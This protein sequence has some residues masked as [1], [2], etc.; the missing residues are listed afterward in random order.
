MNKSDGRKKNGRHMSLCACSTTNAL[1]CYLS[2]LDCY[3]RSSSVQA[4]A[5]S[6][7][8]HRNKQHQQSFFFFFIAALFTQR[9]ISS[10]TS[11]LSADIYIIALEKLCFYCT[12]TKIKSAQMDKSKKMHLSPTKT[13]RIGHLFK[14]VI[15]NSIYSSHLL[16]NTHICVGAQES[17]CWLYR[18]ITR[19]YHGNHSCGLESTE[20]SA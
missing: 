10:L 18:T 8:Q 7:L 3:Y 1:L 19:Y 13:D 2:P 12:F 16:P 9:T 14:Q 6:T 17:V 5:D 4:P 11:T 20:K 15:T